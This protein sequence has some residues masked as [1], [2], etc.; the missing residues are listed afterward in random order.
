MG[1]VQAT[2]PDLSHPH[3]SARSKAPVTPHQPTYQPNQTPETPRNSQG[4][5][6]AAEPTLDKNGPLRDALICGY[7]GFLTRR[8]CLIAQ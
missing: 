3:Q 5:F 7:R 1:C 2:E 4:F 8:S 6:N